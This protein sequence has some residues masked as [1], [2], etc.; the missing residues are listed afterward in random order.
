MSE[1]SEQETEYRYR[2]VDDADLREHIQN[3]IVLSEE[4]TVILGVQRSRVYELRQAGRLVPLVMGN[5]AAAYY[6]PEVLQ[7]RDELA[8]KKESM[9]RRE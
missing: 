9:K 2:F 7:L 8:A 6:L 1:K 4:I 3:N 5:A